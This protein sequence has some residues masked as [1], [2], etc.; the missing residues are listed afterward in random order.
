MKRIRAMDPLLAG[1]MAS[2]RAV[3]V[4]L[5]RNWKHVVFDTDSKFLGSDI[6]NSL[7]TPCWKI[8]DLVLS[9]RKGFKAQTAW[10]L[11]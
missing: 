7:V 3:E 5:I 2:S 10:S 8:E 9:I 4:A 1:A 6:V 11:H